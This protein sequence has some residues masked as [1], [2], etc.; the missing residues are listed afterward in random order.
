MK[1]GR[2][3]EELRRMSAIADADQAERTAPFQRI[4]RLY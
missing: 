1:G 4:F 2:L 3:D